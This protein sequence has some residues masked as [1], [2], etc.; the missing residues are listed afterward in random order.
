MSKYLCPKC[1][2]LSTVT[3]VTM[4]GNGTMT[5]YRHCRMCNINF[6][7]VETV[8]ETPR[9]R[10]WLGEDKASKLWPP[11]PFKYRTIKQQKRAV[12]SST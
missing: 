3:N 6:M 1:K 8:K 11:P 12:K 7:T 4:S 9:V 5:R 10:S 2:Y